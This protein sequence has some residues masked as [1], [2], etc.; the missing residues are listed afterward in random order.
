MATMIPKALPDRADSEIPRSE[1]QIFNALQTGPHTKGWVVMHRVHVPGKR[2]NSNPREVDFLIMA[3]GGGA[4][5]L[6]VKGDVLDVRDGQWFRR[7]DGCNGPPMPQAPNDQAADAMDCLQIYLQKWAKGSD[8]RF[9]QTIRNLPIWYAVAFTDAGWPEDVARPTDC[10]IYDSVVAN[11]PAALCER[12]SRLLK[13][14]PF[15]GRSKSGL[16]PD[17]I[18]FI[19]RSVNPNLQMD[20]HAWTNTFNDSL[21]ELVEL[22]EKQSSVLRLARRNPRVLLEGGAGTGKTL[23]AVKLAKERAAEGEDVALICHSYILADRLRSEFRHFP[24][25]VCE[26]FTEF[27]DWLGGSSPVSKNAR[28]VG[29]IRGTQ[30]ASRISGNEFGAFQEAAGYVLRE[31]KRHEPQFKYLVVDELQ[32]LIEPTMF[33]IFDR[34]LDGGLQHGHWTMFAD[35]SNQSLLMSGEWPEG[36][37]IL[38]PRDSLTAM[39]AAA[40]A[41]D[42]LQE[43]CRNSRNIFVR[44]QHF[45][46]SDTPYRMRAGASDG[47]DVRT[48]CFVDGDEL[49]RMLDEEIGRLYRGGVKREQIVV[50]VTTHAFSTDPDNAAQALLEGNRKFGPGQWTLDVQNI[51]GDGLALIPAS[52]YAGLE[53]DV[54]ILLVSDDPGAHEAISATWEG[55]RTEW[56]VALSR[57]K[58]ELVILA[59]AKLPCHIKQKLGWQPSGAE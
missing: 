10:E 35:F 47:P 42:E 6:E 38:D 20:D 1:R 7:S 46:A 30:R 5:C 48:R 53:S 29:M 50:L 15:R 14:L 31:V 59:D 40:P 4:I 18:D 54:V 25:V 21:K 34:V 41:N 55:I 3:P 39:G 12:L 26:G 52:A 28:L 33:E 9:H 13:D 24:N 56:Y 58:V 32:W 37:D 17:T 22:T 43:N 36:I 44:M 11:D 45:D 2:R 27:L 8:K 23:L 57:P 51:G 16:T 49:E 19:R